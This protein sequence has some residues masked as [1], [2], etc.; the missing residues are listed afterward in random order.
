MGRVGLV[1]ACTWLGFW[2]FVIGQRSRKHAI[3]RLGP[4]CTDLAVVAEWGGDGLPLE[5]FY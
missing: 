2:R 5:D 3:A 4:L 1:M